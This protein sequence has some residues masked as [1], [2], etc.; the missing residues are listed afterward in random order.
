MKKAVQ[1]CAKEEEL[2][3]YPCDEC[4]YEKGVEDGDCVRT[5]MQDVQKWMEE[6]ER[7][8]VDKERESGK[9]K[10]ESLMISIE[11]IDGLRKI[12]EKDEDWHREIELLKIKIRMIENGISCV[13]VAN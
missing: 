9:A 1:Q 5:A 2:K 10:D 6:A 12:A 13:L 3:K 8:I 7:R 4:P 11:D